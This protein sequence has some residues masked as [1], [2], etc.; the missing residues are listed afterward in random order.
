MLDLIPVR[1]V[2]FPRSGHHYVV[3]SLKAYFGPKFRYASVIPGEPHS[4]NPH[5]KEPRLRLHESEYL[6]EPIERGCRYLVQIRDF[7]TLLNRGIR[8]FSTGNPVGGSGVCQTPASILFG[9]P[10]K[11]V[12]SPELPDSMR[13]TVHYA[14]LVA[15]PVVVMREIVKFFGAAV[16]ELRLAQVMENNPPR[17][18]RQKLFYLQGSL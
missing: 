16:D 5:S 11:W 7:W 2:S 10:S 14:D 6:T 18:R 4:E 13:L 1:S 3:E 12:L 9:I 15:N 8:I 17:T